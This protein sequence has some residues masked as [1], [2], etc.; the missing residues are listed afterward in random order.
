VK[1]IVTLIAVSGVVLVAVK[2]AFLPW[3]PYRRLPRNQ[4]RSACRK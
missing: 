4:T 1:T 2:W 3:L